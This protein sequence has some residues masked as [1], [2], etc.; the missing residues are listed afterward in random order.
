MFRWDG[1]F[2]MVMKDQYEEAISW[3]EEV[4]GW[5]CVEKISTLVGEKAFMKMPRSGIVTIKSYQEEYEHFFR[6]QE[7]GDSTLP[8][9][10]YDIE[11]TTSYLKERKVECFETKSLPNGQKYCDIL[12]YADTKMTLFEEEKGEGTN[13]YPPSGMIG[14]GNVNSI[15]TV[16]DLNASSK[17]Y[18]EVLGFKIVSVN[19]EKG[20]AHLKT[21]DAYDR[22]ALRQEFWDHIWLLQDEEKKLNKPNDNSARIYYDIRPSVF[23]DE[24]NQLIKQGIRPSEIAGDP[25]NGWGGFH[26]YD[27]DLN[28]INIWSY[29]FD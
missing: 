11:K 13:E 25:I 16:K 1:G 6:E 8:F 20:Y 3:Y 28:R 2:I 29:T 5:T 22:N 17:W 24:Y 19:E 27:P 26:I 21:E 12:A 4:F 23:F 7:E 14:F 10:T 9:A 15:L 18:K